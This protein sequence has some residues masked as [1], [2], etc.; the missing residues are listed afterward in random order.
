[1]LSSTTNVHD[2]YLAFY[3]LKHSKLS[4]LKRVYYWLR[5]VAV[6]RVVTQ[7]PNVHVEIII[8]GYSYSINE[9][10]KEL[11]KIPRKQYKN[12]N[13][14]LPTFKHFALNDEEYVNLTCFIQNHKCNEPY[15]TWTDYY[16]IPFIGSYI[17]QSKNQW[18]CSKLIATALVSSADSWKCYIKD[19]SHI[20]PE[21]IYQISLHLCETVMAHDI[22]SLE[23]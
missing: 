5:Y 21:S 19:P 7:I 23:V 17:P 11:H 10:E 2:I 12:D 14:E 20:T 13:Y 1:M 15:D 16:F 4:N 9:T 22:R 8:D 6:D 18:F 3:K